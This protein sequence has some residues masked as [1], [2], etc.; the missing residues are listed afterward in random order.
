MLF[1]EKGDKKFINGHTQFMYVLPLESHTA[2]IEPTRF[3]TQI[4]AKTEAE[5]LIVDY[6]K[7]LSTGYEVLEMES[8]VIPMAVVKTPK[9]EN[10]NHI[11]TGAVFGQIKPSTGYSFER[12]LR[13]AE[14][15]A[16]SLS[17]KKSPIQRRISSNRFSKTAEQNL[18][19]PKTVPN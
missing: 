18:L 10:T 1:F 2:L 7:Q 15:I 13:D 11:P 14:S 16:L 8:G 6:L 19:W 17:E 5:S 12:N 3:G 9:P 4:I